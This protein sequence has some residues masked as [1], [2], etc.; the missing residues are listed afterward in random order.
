MSSD[1]FQKA[2]GDITKKMPFIVKDVHQ[3]NFIKKLLLDSPRLSYVFGGGIVLGRFIRF[4]GPESGCKSIICTYIGAQFQKNLPIQ[5]P[6]FKHKKYVVYVDVERTFDPDYAKEVGIDLSE[7]CFVLLQPQNFEDLSLALEPL[8]R[9]DQV[10]CVIFDS[11]SFITTRTIQLDEVGKANFGSQ[12]KFM[13]DF[14]N[15][16]IPLCSD[17]NTTMFV[18]SQERAQ[19]NTLSKALNFTGGFSLKYAS[20]VTNRVKKIENLTK[21]SKIVGVHLQVRNYKNKTG[22]P[23]RECEMD[24]YYEGGF[25]STGEYIDFLKEF[26]DEPRLQDLVLVKAGG[27]YKSEKFGWS[28]RGKDALVEAIKSNTLV[29]WDQIKATIDDIIKNPIEGKENTADPEQELEQNMTEEQA[30]EFDKQLEE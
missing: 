16:F 9:T 10:S 13:K 25:D 15:R 29:G 12:A 8:I 14:C 23:F 5:F 3:K 26:A 28:F 6:E 1:A 4:F 21:G 20:S 17:Y 24:L 2:L 11:E 19:M 18:I 7:G 27:N 30:D 22:I